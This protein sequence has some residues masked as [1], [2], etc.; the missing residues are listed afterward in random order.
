ME[1]ELALIK[2]LAEGG[3]VTALVIYVVHLLVKVMRDPE[4]LGAWLPRLLATWHREMTKAE[5]ARRKH[6]E[7]KQKRKKQKPAGAASEQ[8]L[9]DT[10]APKELPATDGTG[11]GAGEQTEDK[12]RASQR[13]ERVKTAEVPGESAR[14][15]PH[16]S[17]ASHRSRAR[18]RERTS[19][20][21]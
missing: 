18:H 11:V 3:G 10:D 19:A 17:G 14:T 1:F 4:R 7:A 6:E 5:K 15:L 2:A 9:A 8:Q 13:E 16:H 21:S 12:V 20:P